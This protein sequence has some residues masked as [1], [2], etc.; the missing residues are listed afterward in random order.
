MFEGHLKRLGEGEHRDQARYPMPALYEADL[1]PVD[2]GHLGALVLRESC[3]IARGA[4]FR[5]ELEGELS[6]F[7]LVG[8]VVGGRFQSEAPYTRLRQMSTVT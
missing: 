2:A 5:A 3:R 6:A 4:E 8:G 7:D 1:A